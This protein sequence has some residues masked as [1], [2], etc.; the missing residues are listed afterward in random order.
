LVEWEQLYRKL[1]PGAKQVPTPYSKLDLLLLSYAESLVSMI[2]EPRDDFLSV[3][4]S[5]PTHDHDKGPVPSPPPWEHFSVAPSQPTHDHDIRTVS[6][7]HPWDYVGVAFGYPRRA[8][9]TTVWLSSG[10]DFEDDTAFTMRPEVSESIG[11]RSAESARPHSGAPSEQEAT[12][13]SSS[14]L[15]GMVESD[16]VVPQLDHWLQEPDPWYLSSDISASHARL[17]LLRADYSLVQT[18]P[19]GDAAPPIEPPKIS[20]AQSILPP[21]SDTPDDLRCPSCHA[22]FNG[23]YRRGNLS[24]HIRIKHGFMPT[25]LYVCEADGCSRVYH[26]HDARLKH[27]RKQH[28]GLAPPVSARRR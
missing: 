16:T 18:R 5:Q 6:P 23:T 27:Y 14:L 22:S 9:P 19:S 3:A 24:R 21:T 4:P 2:V 7:S 12:R 25:R 15:A 11:D 17:G 28:P 13:S 1:Y 26:R 20:D 10:M 8:S